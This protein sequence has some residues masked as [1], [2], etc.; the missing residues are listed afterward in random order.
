MLSWLTSRSSPLGSL[1]YTVVPPSDSSPPFPSTSLIFQPRLGKQ[2]KTSER[3]LISTIARGNI[4]TDLMPLAVRH[5]DNCRKL[6]HPSLLKVLDA[7]DEGDKEGGSMV[8]VTE[9]AR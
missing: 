5:F 6:V 2:T 1:P 4:P 8:I 7:V 9:Y 3:C